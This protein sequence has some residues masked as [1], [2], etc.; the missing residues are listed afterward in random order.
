VIDGIEPPFE[1][2]GS[3]RPQALRR[4]AVPLLALQLVGQEMLVAERASARSELPILLRE[5]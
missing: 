3:D 4:E 5:P 2:G 1:N